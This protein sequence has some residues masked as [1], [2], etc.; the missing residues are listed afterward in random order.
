MTLP[1]LNL[2][3]DRQVDMAAI[4]KRIAQAGQDGLPREEHELLVADAA[5]GLK[6]EIRLMKAEFA[7]AV[8]RFLDPETLVRDACTA[9]SQTDGLWECEWSTVLGAIM[10]AGQL[11]LRIGTGLGHCWILPFW[12]TAAGCYRAQ[13]VIGYKGYIDLCYRSGLVTGIRSEIVY[14]SEADSTEP[15]RWKEF[16]WDEQ[17]PH[18]YH[19]PDI[20]IVKRHSCVLC[21]ETNPDCELFLAD[22]GAHGEKIHAFYAQARTRNGGVN[23]ARPWGLGMMLDHRRRYAKKTKAGVLK[24]PWRDEFPQM[25]KKTLLRELTS[26]LPKSAEVSHALAADGG[27]RYNF[28]SG[29]VQP[30]DAT[31]HERENV[32]IDAEEVIGEKVHPLDR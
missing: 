10:S 1:M 16:Y 31:E 23:V 13:L 30:A 28:S 3:A 29:G 5:N 32:I 9:V 22:P 7:K 20:N 14:Q 26:Q 17:G 27:V 25:G 12:S 19:R 18:L 11:G 4:R 15:V 8:P 21:N 6:R 24:G 2:P